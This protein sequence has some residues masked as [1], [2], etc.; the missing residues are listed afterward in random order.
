MSEPEYEY[1]GVMAQTWDLFRSDT[2]NWDDRCLIIMSE[3]G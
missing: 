1:H 2:S 3:M